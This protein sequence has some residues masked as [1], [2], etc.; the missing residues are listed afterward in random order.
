MTSLKLFFVFWGHLAGADTCGLRTAY[1]SPHGKEGLGLGA[2][3]L[4]R[5]C[6]GS[7]SAGSAEG[8]VPI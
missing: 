3:E 5:G 2:V 4:W 1:T 7:G 6:S 8:A